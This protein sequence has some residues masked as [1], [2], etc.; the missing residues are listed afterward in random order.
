M[1]DKPTSETPPTDGGIKETFRTL[2]LA[3]LI[4]LS[5][6]TLAFEPFNI[7]SSSMVPTLLIGDYLFVSKYSYGY[8]NMGTFW[9]LIPFKGRLLGN[10]PKRGDVVVFKTPRDNTTDYIKR[11]IGLPGDTVQMRQGILY[12]NGVP[13]DRDR[14]QHPLTGEQLPPVRTAT[15]DYQETLPGG[16]TH[17]I[18]KEGDNM[19][20][21]NTDVFVV[22]AHHYFFM[23]DNRDNSQDSRT[24]MVGFVPE[25][26]LVGHAEF[27]FLSLSD[28]APFWQFWKWPTSVR[29]DRL[30][31]KIR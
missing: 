15:T 22:P 31:T 17:I 24:K 9:G 7:P 21:D 19:P 25:E 14:L 4:A 5:I 16:V 8:G 10:E 28:G 29:W 3:M 2:L 13:V 12:I 26:N 6:R 20:L 30:F 1:T 18:R 23:G 11:L 27:L